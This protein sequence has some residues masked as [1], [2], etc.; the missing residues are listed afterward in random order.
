MNLTVVPRKHRKHVE[1][2]IDEYHLNLGISDNY[3]IKWSEFLTFKYTG[4]SDGWIR[5]SD[6]EYQA[7]M[8]LMDVTE[9]I[10]FLN[11]LEGEE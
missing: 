11:V 9:M 1:K 6:K 2:L 7:L 5:S 3:F 4:I 8:W 10:N